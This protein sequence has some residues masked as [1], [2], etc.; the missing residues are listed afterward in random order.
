MI[1]YIYIGSCDTFIWGSSKNLPFVPKAKK[2]IPWTVKVKPALIQRI[3]RLPVSRDGSRT[4]G[5][6]I[7]TGFWTQQNHDMRSMT[8]ST[9]QWILFFCWSD[10]SDVFFVLWD[11]FLGVWDCLGSWG[12]ISKVLCHLEIGS[13]PH[14]PWR[15][16][17]RVGN[18]WRYR[19]GETYF[20]LSYNLIYNVISESPEVFEGIA[21]VSLSPKTFC[22]RGFSF[23]FQE[24]ES[25]WNICIQCLCIYIY[26]LELYT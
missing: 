21:T 13:L 26:I 16:P 19:S 20:L 24:V 6:Q 7:M 11:L 10:V 14:F 2:R 1:L 17:V 12:W 3:Q 18:R 5:R 15:A 22:I 8:W 23:S 25:R 4:L 9:C